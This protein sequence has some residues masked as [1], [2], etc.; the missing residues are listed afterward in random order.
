[1]CYKINVTL[2]YY[3]DRYIGRDV[4]DKRRLCVHVYMNRYIQRN[5]KHYLY[6][7]WFWPIGCLLLFFCSSIGIGV[8]ITVMQM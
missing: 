6:V 2:N 5:L 7:I 1:M 8:C 4:L 3:R